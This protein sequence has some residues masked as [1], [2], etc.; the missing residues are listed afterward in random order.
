MSMVKR[1][2]RGLP[3]VATRP[4]YEP[5]LVLVLLSIWKI[6]MAERRYR[7]LSRM[8]TMPSYD[9]CNAIP[10]PVMRRPSLLASRCRTM[11]RQNR[12]EN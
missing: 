1:R 9:Y 5:F 11:I 7:G 4:W 10:V 8:A 6:S 2:Y 3:S 12:Q